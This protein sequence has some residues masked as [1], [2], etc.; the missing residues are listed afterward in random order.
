MSA[1]ARRLPR[2]RLNIARQEFEHMLQ[3]GIVQPS[4][5]NWSSPLHMVPKKTP[6]DWRPCGDYRALN[7]V[8]VPDRYPIPHIQDFAASLS[9]A[10]IF[11]KIDSVRAYHQIPVEPTDI[12]KTAVVTPFGLYEFVRM[13]FGLR[14]AAQTFQRFRDQVLRGLHFCYDYIDDLLIASSGPEEHERHLRLVLERLSDHGILVNPSKCVFGVDHLEFLGHYVD[15]NGI[16][17]L[18]DKVQV[19]RAF[20]TPT[21]QRKLREFL[22]LV[23]FYHRFIPHAATILQPLNRLLST[24]KDKASKLTWTADATTAFTTIKEALAKATLLFHPQPD[25]PTSIMTDASD[26]AVGAVLQQRIAGDLQP[27]AYFSKKLKPAET[28]YS[29]FDRELLA[30]YLSVK[31]FRHFVEGRTFQ[32]LTDHKPLMYA[33]AT[34]SAR[35]TP[36]QIRRL[37][38]ISQ[39]TTDIRH[40]SGAD[41]PAAD[42]L[43]R[44]GANAHYSFR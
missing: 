29:T 23:N 38:Y 31:H 37:D 40:V 41:N 16:R 8:T 24:P 15:S 36:R 28:R 7:N 21:T 30:M 18:E 27:I 39:F 17:P 10:T 13:P 3:L 12:P 34:P 2:E 20:P 32:I 11:S 25:A 42:A 35:H 5:S 33:L 43:S 19:I 14:N 9:G 4:S 6:G 26:V 44:I 1:R 22:G